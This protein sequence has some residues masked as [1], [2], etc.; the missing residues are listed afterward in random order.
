MVTKDDIAWFKSNFFSKMTAATKGTPLT[1]DFLTA[2][3]CQESGEIWP[4][5]RKKLASV[6]EVM[7]LC[8]GDTLDGRGAFPKTRAELLSKPDGQRM[9]EMGREALVSMANVVGGTYKKVAGNPKKYCHAFG[10]YQ[11]DIQHFLKEPD[12][13]L[14]RQWATFDGS[15]RRAMGV[16]QFALKKR[17]FEGRSSLS[18]FELATVGIVYNTGGYKESK[19]L[20]QGFQPEGGKHY[21]QALFDLIRLAHTVPDPG[22]DAPL[23]ETPAAG[24]AL[25]AAPSP[26]TRD[27]TPMKVAI[28]DGMLRVRS[29]PRISDP[30]QANVV[31]HLPDGHPVRALAG[32][33]K[34]FFQIETSLNGALVQGFCSA[35]FLVAGPSNQKIDVSRPADATA[36]SR[37]VEVNMPEKAGVVTRRKDRAT[38]RSLNEKGAPGRSG[39][40]PA[41]LRAELGAIVDYLDVENPD[42]LRYQP[43]RT[44]TFCN[45]YAHDFCRLAGAYIPRVWWSGQALMQLAQGKSVQPLLG[46][47]LFEMRANDLFRWL[48]DFG[49]GFGWR[50]TGTLT[51]LQT[52]ANQGAIGVIVARRREDGK[53]GHIVI[54]VPETADVTAKRDATGEV[55]APVQSQAGATNFKRGR[56]RANWWKGEEF[57]ESAF[58]LHA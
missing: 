49:A 37:V 3:A 40:T 4:I 31:A 56:G 15:L 2:L 32:P 53:S 54:V 25:I 43:T 5:A 22:A 11:V 45:I 36:A 1:V 24:Q 52:E 38:A 33:T 41:A 7:A 55:V 6:D 8:V 27:G 12:Y 29:E 20:E 44:A 10:V 51:K 19:G 16:L 14:Q 17:G 30:P 28:T 34:G 42:F 47:T 46:N 21:G 58:W 48:R 9:F 39:T 57:A 50:Q 18:D 23:L 26:V 35:K 13:F